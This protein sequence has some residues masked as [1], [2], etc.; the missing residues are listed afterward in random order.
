MTPDQGD[1]EL[2]E[3]L[4]GLA[5]LERLHALVNYARLHDLAQERR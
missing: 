4:L 5:P 1:L 2:A 3:L